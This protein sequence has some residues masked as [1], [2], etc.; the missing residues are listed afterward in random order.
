MIYASEGWLTTNFEIYIPDNFIFRVHLTH[1]ALSTTTFTFSSRQKKKKKI[2]KTVLGRC[3][4]IISSAYCQKSYCRERVTFRGYS[5]LSAEKFLPS[6]QNIYPKMD[7]SFLKKMLIQ[8]EWMISYGYVCAHT[9]H[10]RKISYIGSLMV[11]IPLTAF[12]NCSRHYYTAGLEGG[13]IQLKICICKCK[14]KEP[15]D[16]CKFFTGFP[17]KR[18][19]RSGGRNGTR[20]PFQSV[21]FLSCIASPVFANKELFTWLFNKLDWKATQVIS[22]QRTGVLFFSF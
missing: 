17:D 14:R 13:G 2:T 20:S 3:K 5:D 16:L 1:S 19:S 6:S 10:G 12:F 15:H 11:N 21:W 22:Q 4:Y 8:G 18:F 9:K 7:T